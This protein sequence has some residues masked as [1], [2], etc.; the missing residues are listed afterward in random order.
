MTS[1]PQV[2]DLTA[3]PE[4]R[5][6]IAANRHWYIAVESPTFTLPNLPSELIDHILAYLSPVDLASVCLVNQTLRAHALADHIWQ[7]LVQEN[8]PGVKVT[9][10]G[11]CASFRELYIAHDPHWFLT[12]YKLWFSDKDLTGKLMLACY[13]QNTG[14][15]AGYQLLAQKRKTASFSTPNVMENIV[16]EVHE[17]DPEVKLFLDKP[18]MQLSANSLENIMRATARKVPAEPVATPPAPAA[19]GLTGIAA[20]WVNTFGTASTPP[21]PQ[22]PVQPHRFAAETPMPLNIRATDHIFSNFMLAKSL[23]AA[24]TEEKSLEGFPYGNMWPPP[25]IPATERVAS[26]HYANGSR[27]MDHMQANKVSPE[28]R[29]S[30]RSE[31]SDKTFRVRSWLERPTSSSSG[32]SSSRLPF[33]NLHLPPLGTT[34]GLFGQSTQVWTPN[35][36][37][38]ASPIPSTA[39]VQPSFSAH[40]WDS[41]ST[42]STVD[43]ELYTPTADQP[44]KGIWVGDYSGHGCEFLVVKQHHATPFDEAAFDATRSEGETEAEFARRKADARKYRGSMEAIKLTGDANVPR[45]E[46]TFKAADLGEDGYVATITADQFDGT[47]VVHA[48]GHVA[49]T[50]FSN[51]ELLPDE[52]VRGVLSDCVANSDGVQIDISTRNYC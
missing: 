9:T 48:K 35:Y 36:D 27:H 7:S 8:V 52:I 47:R 49:M 44:W 51:G 28:D 24:V 14:V 15:I 17:F 19:K 33:G 1:L 18:V 32:S 5:E 37:P 21:T 22:P 3:E 6:A 39:G 25:A 41:V 46:C 50:G 16:L 4:A 40:I 30:K 34:Q 31:I 26:A 11:P 20:R 43:P 45:G 29:P 42:Y 12:K 10:P 23:P 38:N 2:C 13:D